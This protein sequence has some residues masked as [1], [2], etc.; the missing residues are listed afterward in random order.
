MPSAGA[1]VSGAEGLLRRLIGKHPAVC[2]LTGLATQVLKYNSS[3]SSL[4]MRFPSCGP[5][6]HALA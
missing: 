3:S 2:M 5:P 1:A 6:P 4:V